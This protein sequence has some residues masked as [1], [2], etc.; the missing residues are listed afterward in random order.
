MAFATVFLFLILKTE[1][2]GN[3]APPA[4]GASFGSRFGFQFRRSLALAHQGV[5]LMDSIYLNVIF[6]SFYLGFAL[7]V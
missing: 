4:V 6:K 5:D 7:E 2:I 1:L 3:H